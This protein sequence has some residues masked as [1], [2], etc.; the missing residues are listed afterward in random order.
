MK[1]LILVRPK[2]SGAMFEEL[3]EALQATLAS[4]TDL[5]YELKI[6]KAGGC[7]TCTKVAENAKG[8]TVAYLLS[9]GVLAV[10][11]Q[12]DLLMR[13]GV[14]RLLSGVMGDL[15]EGET[16]WDASAYVRD[17]WMQ[18]FPA[19]TDGELDPILYSDGTGQY[20]E[21]RCGDIH[22][23]RNTTRE[24]FEAYV[25]GMVALGYRLTFENTI[26]GNRYANLF[27]VLGNNVYVYYMTEVANDK[28]GV[29]RTVCDRSSTQNHPVDT[30]GK[31]GI[32]SFHSANTTA[33]FYKQ[34]GGFHNATNHRQ[35][36][37]GAEL[38]ALQV[39][40]MDAAC[41]CILKIKSNFQ[42][43]FVINCHLLVLAL[44]ETYR[45]PLV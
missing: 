17:G 11:A 6:G 44:I 24:A 4:R 36:G 21:E 26:D 22:I 29:V 39:Y 34:I 30:Q 7:A 45:F 13:L 5:A 19:Y 27:D 18:N 32:H 41:A 23:V 35:I 33:N 42:R 16:L 15:A 43:I 38:S 8:N 3:C 12:S 40:H 2:Q 10:A 1:K 20:E 25:A 37:S 28:T 31:I 14:Q 9:D